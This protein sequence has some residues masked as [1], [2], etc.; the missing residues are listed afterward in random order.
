MSEVQGLAHLPHLSVLR[1][2]ANRIGDGCRFDIN[3]L[4]S[5]PPFPALQVLQLGQN[6]IASIER[7]GLNCLTGLRSLFLQ[8]NALLS[9][10]CCLYAVGHG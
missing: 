4:G 6:C 5:S 9:L 8:V 2:G 7:L 3:P 1:L 10:L